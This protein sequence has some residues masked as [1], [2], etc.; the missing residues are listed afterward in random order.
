MLNSNQ[1]EIKIINLL[2]RNDRREESLIELKKIN[3][4]KSDIFHEAK[5]V[6]EHGAIGCAL[7]HSKVLFDFMHNTNKNVLMTLEDD[8]EINDEI[9]FIKTLNDVINS[10]EPWDVFLLGHNQA[11][12]IEITS[13]EG[14]NRVIN[15]QTTS[16]YLVKRKY[17]PILLMNF[18]ES[19][20]KLNQYKNLPTPN[21]ELAVSILAMDIYWKKL[22]LKDNFI[23]AIPALIKQRKSYSDIYKDVVDYKT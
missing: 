8:F 12:P 10:N 17:A 7:S 3:L 4:N 19:A 23:A 2:H 1:L 6:P 18:L 21:K 5:F 15:A 16:G 11:I 9:N 13:I 14:V 22:Q 20:N